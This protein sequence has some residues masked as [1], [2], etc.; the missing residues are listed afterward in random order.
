MTL[1][2]WNCKSQ[3]DTDMH[4][5]TNDLINETSPYLLQHAHNP[6][7]WKPWNEET[8]TLAKKENKLILVSIGYS[9][10]HWCHVM[11]HESFEDSLVAD[12]MNANF[13]N[14]KVDREERPDVDNVYMSAV[15]LMTGRA[16]G[17]PLNA[18]T[19]PDGRPIWGGTYFPK[20]DWTHALKQVS[21]AFIEN[22][23]SLV[24]FADKLA[25]GIKTRNIVT[26]NPNKPTF[27]EETIIASLDTWS[28][29]WDTHKGG[30][31]SAPKF[32]MPNNYQFL[33]RYAH[34]AQNEELLAYVNTTLQQIAYGGVNDHVGGGFS[35]YSTDKNWHIPHFEKM[36]YDN[37]QL[38][39]LYSDA[40]LVTKNELYKE[41]VYQT[42]EYVAR[43][44]TTPDGSFYSALDAD[45]LN[46]EEELEEG[47][48]YV[49]TK[50]ELKTLLKEDF[51]LFA[52]YYNINSY[53]K[54][55]KD[56]YVLIRK[57]TDTDFIKE[58]GLTIDSFKEKQTQWKKDLLRF[59][60]SNKE[61]PRLDDKILTGWN[62]LMTK[63]YIDAYRVFNEQRFLDIALKNANFIVD[64][65]L[66]KDGGLD[67]NYKNGKS[68][69][70]AYLEDYASTIDAFIALFE[71]TTDVVWLER[72]KALT[73]YTFTHFQDKT[74]SM[75]FFTSN[76]D[77]D[78]ISRNTEYID[79][80]IPASNS[81]MAKNIFT[82]S[83]YYLDKA[84][85]QTVVT[86]L[87]NIQPEID[88]S[89]TAFS[90]WLDLHLN[91]TKPYYE[92]VVV[93]SKAKEVLTE[94][95]SLYLPNKL[96]A[97]S[98]GE[99]TQEIFEG[100]YLKNETLIYVCVNN[101]CKL[102]VKTVEEALKLIKQ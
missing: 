47:A 99:S 93:G 98:T 89:P 10:C 87:N 28:T 68:A 39:S 55:E 71:V 12:F 40:Y 92:L 50:A 82:L 7:N 15:E 48:Y 94:L 85:T 54:W 70:N 67:R 59:R 91:Y 81:M 65:M 53:G 24:E 76:E 41:T 80:V 21:S 32:M 35:R 23:N 101:A 9:S 51:D 77:L 4:K 31:N 90:N 69:I 42:L 2:L 60:E 8:L 45:S 13:I 84:Y 22:P 62:G 73:D 26:T 61:R 52:S 3:D 64:N 96:I 20:E 25:S 63:G 46:N 34:Q 102:P 38:V 83:H 75:F 95:N 6:V 66:R 43:E 58:H 57:D 18:I 49:W 14:I 27:K 88:K 86:M 97:A 79:K 17:W 78:L 44:M 56:N 36:L 33:L 16:G 19:L 5:Y 74:N 72:A 37:A 29:Y 11:E 1:I 100:R 30:I